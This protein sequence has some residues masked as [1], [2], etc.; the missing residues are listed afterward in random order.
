[1]WCGVRYGEVAWYGVLCCGLKW[2]G[3][4]CLWYGMVY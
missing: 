4:E 3:V 1:M 2:S